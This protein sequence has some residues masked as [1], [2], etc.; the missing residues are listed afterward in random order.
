[1]LHLDVIFAQ[2]DTIPAVVSGLRQ[3][4]RNDSGACPVLPTVIRLSENMV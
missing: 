4:V 2:C 1:M 3:S